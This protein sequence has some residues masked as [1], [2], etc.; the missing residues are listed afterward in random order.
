MSQRAKWSRWALRDNGFK[1]RRSCRARSIRPL[2]TMR[3]VHRRTLQLLRHRRPGLAARSPSS[4]SRRS[5]NSWLV[6]KSMDMESAA[7][8]EPFA[9]GRACGGN[10]RPSRPATA[11]VV[12]GPGPIGLKRGAFG[13]RAR[14]HLDRRS[15]GS[16]STLSAWSWRAGWDFKTVCASD[17]DWLDQVRALMP[18]GGADVVFDASGALD[19]ARHIVRKG[20]G[21]SN[22]DG[23]RATSPGPNCARSSS[24]ASSI[25]PS[26][27][28]TPETWRRAI[29]TVA[30]GA[31]DP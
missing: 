29:A 30:S 12:E 21:W 23:R 8:L 27:V 26:R 6:P 25:I 13:A 24:T 16:K 14:G 17:R 22:S 31:V 9:T 28:R 4:A 18:P 11:A 2:R 10:L 20:G 7:M 19:S 5:A 3:P 15:L 1:D